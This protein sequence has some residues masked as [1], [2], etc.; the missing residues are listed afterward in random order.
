[1]SI[2]KKF[3]RETFDHQ[4]RLQHIELNYPENFN[5]A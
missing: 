3:C 4:G 2:Y 1:M 5:F